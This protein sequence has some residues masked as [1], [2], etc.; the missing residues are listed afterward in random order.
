MFSTLNSLLLD[1]Q[2]KKKCVGGRGEDTSQQAQGPQLIK[3]ISP[4]SEVTRSKSESKEMKLAILIPVSP[5]LA[6]E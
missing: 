4:W 6:H 5:L 3:S 2:E 1:W